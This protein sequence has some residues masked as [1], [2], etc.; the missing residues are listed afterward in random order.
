MYLVHQIQVYQNRAKGTSTLASLQFLGLGYRGWASS[1]RA[2]DQ[3]HKQALPTLAGGVVPQGLKCQER[4]KRKLL[5]PIMQVFSEQRG[6]TDEPARFVGG[7]MSIISD[8]CG[9]NQRREGTSR[10]SPLEMKPTSFASLLSGTKSVSRQNRP[11]LQRSKERSTAF[12]R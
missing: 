12:P 1:N 6:D 8:L 2:P 10:N 11:T 7:F 4:Y 5:P 3:S 9:A